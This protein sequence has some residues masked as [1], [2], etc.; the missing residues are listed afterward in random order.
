VDILRRAMKDPKEKNPQETINQNKPLLMKRESPQ[1]S[2][3]LQRAILSPKLMTSANILQLQ[4]TIGN[5]A[6][7][8]FLNDGLH[9]DVSSKQPNGIAQLARK[10]FDS[11]GAPSS[12]AAFNFQTHIKYGNWHFH[13]NIESASK[14][15]DTFFVTLEDYK[16]RK[17]HV[18]FDA[19]NQSINDRLGGGLTATERQEILDWATNELTTQ[20]SA[21]VDVSE[22][23]YQERLD[24]VEEQR[25]LKEEEAR[26]FQ[27]EVRLKELEEAAKSG[28]K[29]EQYILT[30]KLQYKESY[31][32]FAFSKGKEKVYLTSLTEVQIEEIRALL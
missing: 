4:R 20:L 26:K 18:F 5:K 12:S 29:L 24:A 10:D 11:T 31:I 9:N 14:T 13:F 25:K 22:V 16:G 15:V 21:S 23:E 2:Q 1:S 30:N 19:V 32:K 3:M 8:G 6:L 28:N 27:E 7:S 17:R